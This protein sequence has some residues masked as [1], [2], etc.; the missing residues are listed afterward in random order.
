MGILNF[1]DIVAVL[2][3]HWILPY[4]YCP[5]PP[6]PPTFQFLSEVIFLLFKEYCQVFAFI[7]EGYFC[8]V[9]NLGY[10][11]SLSAH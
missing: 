8:W 1:A 11:Y 5:P 3:S 2:C 10:V 7:F 4:I 6:F 9:D